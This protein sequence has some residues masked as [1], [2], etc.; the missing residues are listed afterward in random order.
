MKKGIIKTI[1]FLS[2]ALARLTIKRF[3]PIVIVV[4]GS[5]GKTSTKEALWSVIKNK[6]SV[7]KTSANFN[8][9]LGVPLTI[10]GNWE[11]I[12]K[13]AWFFWIKVFIF[14][15]ANLLFGKKS[16]YPEVLVLEY[17][18]D[19]PGDISHLVDIAR[20]SVGIISAIGQIPVHIENYSQ[21]IDSVIREKGKI[22]SDMM[23]GDTAVLNADDESVNS[24]RFKTRAKVLTFGL[25]KEADVRICNFKHMILDNKI[26]GIAFKL[27]NGGASV[28][29][30]LRH[31]FSMSHAYAAASAACVASIFDIN[32]IE[33]A[34]LFAIHYKPVKGRSTI[35]DGIK[36][37][38]II[39]ESYNSSPL[40]LE[41]ALKTIA[42]VTHTRKIVVLGDMME[43]GDYTQR[44]H[45]LAGELVSQSADFL[46]TVGLRSKFIAQKAIKKGMA[47]DQVFSFEDAHQ[48]SLKLQKIMKT[49]DIIL[50]KG[51]RV[52]GLDEI[53]EEIKSRD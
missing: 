30:I 35:I 4:T 46:I 1:Q 13:P 32:L 53:V 24:I 17:G 48:A 44:A 18:A 15:L 8:N 21:G 39:D 33:A 9:E 47:A 45:E 16:L 12:S 41:V 43:L 11:T 50:I 20:P 14:S 52:I 37:T 34:N 51:S 31:A 7:R 29:I 28:P 10:L 27:E 3:K 6:K 25:S 19:K 36:Q 49:G 22:V 42:Q 5:V 23:V 26:D 40:A 38:Q 2:T